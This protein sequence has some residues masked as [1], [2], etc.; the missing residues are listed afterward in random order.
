MIVTKKVNKMEIIEDSIKELKSLGVDGVLSNVV[1]TKMQTFH[2]PWTLSYVRYDDGIIGCGMANNETKIP[3]DVSFIKAL[4]NTNVYDAIDMLYAMESS[5][6]INSLIISMISALT[7]R[8]W[9]DESIFKKDGY[10]VENLNTPHCIFSE[11]VRNT[12]RVVFVGFAAWDVPCIAEIVREV[13]ITELVDS[14][15]FEVIDIDPEESNVEIF[16]ASKSE[17]IL[18]EA[19]VAV[20]T[21]E[22]L[23]NGT[24]DEI[25]QFSENART[26]IIYGPTSSFY[27]KILFESG[28]DASIV[29]IFP[30]TS[31]FRR[32]F[33]HSRGYWYKMPEVKRIV[34]KRRG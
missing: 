15:D 19:D 21:G 34:V 5:V 32:R 33:V 10:T 25:L 8:L 3:E 27:P 23:V 20:I 22:T 29:M 1:I 30:N 11:F 28:I 12:D 13:N 26:R 17:E 9:R 31:D 14:S 6:F 7:H 18:S 4:L 16:P 2:T 24:L